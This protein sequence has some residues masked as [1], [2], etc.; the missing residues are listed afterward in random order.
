MYSVVS[1]QNVNNR[2]N[3][4]LYAH[5]KQYKYLHVRMCEQ[6]TS[7]YTFK[8][9]FASYE[10]ESSYH[11]LPKRLSFLTTEEKFFPFILSKFLLWAKKLN[12]STIIF[13]YFFIFKKYDHKIYTTSKI[14]FELINC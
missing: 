11:F 5:T 1:T 14:E 13:V 12:A 4:S 2:D 9:T 6:N 3:Y 8:T 10:K 7:S